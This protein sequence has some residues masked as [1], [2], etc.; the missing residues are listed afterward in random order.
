V[1]RI[2]IQ[3]IIIGS[4]LAASLSGCSNSSS[5]WSQE[6]D[7]PWKAKRDADAAAIEN[8]E[9]VEVSLDETAQITS[10]E[11]TAVTEVAMP[12]PEMAVSAPAEPKLIAPTPVPISPA[13]PDIMSAPASAYAVQVYAGST[14]KSVNRYMKDHDLNNLQTVKTRRDGNTLY[15]LV[16]VQPDRSSAKQ[17]AEELEQ[18]TGSM[19]WVRPVSGLQSIAIQ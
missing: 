11:E 13:E 9:F 7:S 16:S 5:T 18:K 10:M 19:P 17:K 15:V 6:D 12:E 4:I 1:K 2:K 8:E 3:D 14:V